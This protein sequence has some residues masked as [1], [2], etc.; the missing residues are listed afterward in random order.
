MSLFRPVYFPLLVTVYKEVTVEMNT[1][2]WNHASRRHPPPP[3]VKYM[4]STPERAPL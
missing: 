4:K 1:L 3:E 2:I